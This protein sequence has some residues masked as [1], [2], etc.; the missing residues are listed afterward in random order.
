MEQVTRI[1]LV[2]KPWQG[3][4]L[5]LNYTCKLF[6][7]KY[8]YNN[9]KILISQDENEKIS[10]ST[11]TKNLKDILHNWLKLLQKCYIIVMI[12]YF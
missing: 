7:I 2:T 8:S 10:N 4:I 3:F 6:L 11:H 9:K 5:P 1:E 12:G